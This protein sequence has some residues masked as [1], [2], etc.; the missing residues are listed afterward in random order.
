M[1]TPELGIDRRLRQELDRLG[2]EFLAD[3]LGQETTRNPANVPALADLAH[4][5]TRLGRLEDGLAVDRR[6][7]DLEPTNPTVHYNLACS[8]ALLSRPLEAMDALEESVRNGYNDLEHLLADDDLAS[9]RTE[10]RFA[11][12]AQALQ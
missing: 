2:Q 8:L 4:V 5:L 7:V 11:D 10:R 9:L 12:L 3:I 6:L 1:A